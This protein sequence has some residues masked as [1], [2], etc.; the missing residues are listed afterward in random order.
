MSLESGNLSNKLIRR[1][2]HRKNNK[3]KKKTNNFVSLLR[4]CVSA[5]KFDIPQDATPLNAVLRFSMGVCIWL[6]AIIL[7][8][9]IVTYLQGGGAKG[10][11]TE[12]KVVTDRTTNTQENNSG[13]IDNTIVITPTTDST[14]S[15]SELQPSGS[16]Y[17]TISNMPIGQVQ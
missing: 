1:R 12:T 7:S 14:S 15:A 6:I 11:D 10:L 9:S 3:N 4:F 8:T 17:P 16:V 13:I 5:G 2:E